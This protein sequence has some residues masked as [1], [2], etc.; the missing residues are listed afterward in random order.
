[1]KFISAFAVLVT[2]TP[3]WILAK[4]AWVDPA[5]A[6][7]E[8]P[9]FAIQ[10][11]YVGNIDDAAWGVQVIAEGNGKFAITAY[12]GGLPGA[13]FSGDKEGRR[14]G[15][16]ER[17]KNGV[18]EATVGE[19]R[20]EIRD[21][22]IFSGEKEFFQKVER[23][24]PTIGAAAPAGA[25]V[26]FDGKSGEA[27]QGAKVE[28]E[29]LC[30][31]IT[32]KEKF[33][34]GTWHVEFRLPYQPKARGQGRGNSGCYLQGRYEVQ[35]LDSFGLEG[36]NNECGGIYTIGAPAVNMAFPPLSWQTYDLEFTE[37]KYD[38]AGRKTE[39]AT[40]T[41]KHNGTVVQKNVALTHATTSAPVK[42]GAETGPLHLQ[43]HGNP[44]RYRNIWFQPKP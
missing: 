11:E 12:P 8:D 9:D 34:S 39:D 20:G 35:M 10:G 38:S 31:G 13:G 19:H 23:K 17:N 7:Q 42:E 25:I 44:V 28:G 27:F 26:L 18:V 1:M 37:A 5:V 3:C 41:V 40:I 29:L 2:L 21:G 36:E 16:A 32:S 24:S 4:D 15:R 14:K 22:K 30:Q 33:G 6:A 43:D